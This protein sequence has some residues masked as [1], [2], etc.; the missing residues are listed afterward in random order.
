[1][2]FNEASSLQETTPFRLEFDG[3]KGARWICLSQ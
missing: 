3:E 1:M 2:E